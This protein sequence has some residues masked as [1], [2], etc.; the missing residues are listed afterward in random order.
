MRLLAFLLAS[1]EV[2]WC[3]FNGKGL[4]Q[5]QSDDNRKIVKFSGGDTL[6]STDTNGP[7]VS[8]GQVVE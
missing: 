2:L 1:D 8:C 3:P 7:Q 6:A 4:G 5:L